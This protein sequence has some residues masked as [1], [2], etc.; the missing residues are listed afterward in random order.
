M[1]YL[2]LGLAVF[3]GLIL[4]GVALAKGKPA[5]LAKAVRWLLAILGVAVLLYLLYARQFGWAWFAAVFLLPALMRRRAFARMAK[6]WR[7][8]TPGQKSEIETRFLRMSLDHDTGA[9]DGSVIEGVFKGRELDDLSMVE[10][11]SLLAMCRSG[12][13]QS[14]RLLEAYLDRVHGASWRAHDAGGEWAGDGASSGGGA[15]PSAM[16]REEAYKVLGLGPGASEEDIK[17]A[18]RK[19]MTKIHPDHGGSTYLAAKINQAK[20]VLL[21]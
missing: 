16:G 18:H 4:L 6:N 3:V 7:G 10:Q 11:L 8:P 19:L 15:A 2:V 20:D 9:M 5:T 13:E 1:P 21:G 12:D 17:G 14:A